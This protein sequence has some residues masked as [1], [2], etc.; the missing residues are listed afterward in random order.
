MRKRSLDLGYGAVVA[1]VLWLCASCGDDPRPPPSQFGHVTTGGSG[2]K[3][4]SSTGARGG[5]NAGG[6]SG[7]GGDGPL[8]G[9]TGDA[10]GSGEGGASSGRG[11]G[12]GVGNLGAQGGGGNETAEGG[13]LLTGPDLE[14]PKETP[15]TPTTPPLCDPAASW[16]DGALVLPES[17]GPDVLLAITPDEL[18]IAWRYD[19]SL[20]PKL[21]VA[22]RDSVDEDFG[23]PVLIDDPNAPMA[24][25]IAL[26]PTRLR[27]LA[28]AGGQF[29]E[30]DRAAP[31]EA[32]MYAGAGHFA[33]I[34][35]DAGVQA[36][37]LADPVLGADDETLF[38]SLDAPEGSEGSSLHA[39]KRTGGGDFPVGSPLDACELEQLRNGTRRPTGVSADGLTLFYHDEPRAKMRAAWRPSLDR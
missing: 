12:G 11:G 3:G 33:A 29:I 15:A 13:A 27:L 1:S 8:A 23:E 7:E 28:V 36:R 37:L 39:S 35:A 9:S 18:T 34:N 21:Y 20:F 6:N 22:D 24:N 19:D 14:C 32:F 30:F 16:G 38:Y 25:Q 31:G 2:A 26:G 5:T 17:T 4:G 10:G